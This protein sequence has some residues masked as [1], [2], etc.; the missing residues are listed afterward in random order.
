MIVV[1]LSEVYPFQTTQYQTTYEEH[2]LLM[3][4]KLRMLVGIRHKNYLVG[5]RKR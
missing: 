5:F 3:E 4:C 2:S 1:R